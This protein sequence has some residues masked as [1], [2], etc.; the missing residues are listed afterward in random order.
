MQEMLERVEQRESAPKN[1]CAGHHDFVSQE[2]Y[3]CLMYSDFAQQLLPTALCAEC[4]R[5]PEIRKN[6]TGTKYYPNL[7]LLNLS[8]IPEEDDVS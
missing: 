7:L 5:K 4:A 1:W 8:Y 2:T 3:H 6:I